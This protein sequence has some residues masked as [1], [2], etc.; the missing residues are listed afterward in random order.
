MLRAIAGMVGPGE[1]DLKPELNTIHLLV[2]IEGANGWRAA[3]F[4]STPARFD[5]C[6]EESAAL[7]DELRA[8]LRR[9]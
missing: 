6:P 4:Q 8:E 7:T 3:H 5:G 2:A 1:S 9:S